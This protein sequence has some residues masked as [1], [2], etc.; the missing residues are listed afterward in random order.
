MH[1]SVLQEAKVLLLCQSTSNAGAEK[2]KARLAAFV[3][4]IVLPQ[5]LHFKPWLGIKHANGN[6]KFYFILLKNGIFKNY[7]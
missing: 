1:I 5:S 4:H 7:I 6:V 2:K 3:P